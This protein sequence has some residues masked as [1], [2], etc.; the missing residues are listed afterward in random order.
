MPQ[1]ITDKSEVAKAVGGPAMIR[2]LPKLDRLKVGIKVA[3]ELGNKAAVKVCARKVIE[4]ALR[5]C[6][7][8]DAEATASKI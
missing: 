4:N 6:D 3:E 5:T 1:K 2:K 7:F 8:S